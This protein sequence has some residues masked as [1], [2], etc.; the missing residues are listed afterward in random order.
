MDILTDKQATS[1]TKK[2]ERGSK[3]ETLRKKLNIF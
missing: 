3:K 2:L 1:D